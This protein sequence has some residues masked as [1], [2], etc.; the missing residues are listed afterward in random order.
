MKLSKSIA[1]ATALVISITSLACSGAG[2]SPTATLKAYFEAMQK[3]DAAALKKTL[4]KGTLE[5]FEQFAKAQSP[6][7]TLD[8]A[9]QTGLSSTTNTE[10]NKVPETRNEKIDGDKATLEVKNDKTGQWEAVPFVKEDGNWKI[11]FDQMFRDA[12]KSTGSS[13][14]SSTGNA[15]GSSSDNS[16]K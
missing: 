12:S 5:M 2:S 8:E 4:S 9:L 11:A 15:N 7:K 6:P 10:S 14:G 3:K 13:S 16:N 1:L